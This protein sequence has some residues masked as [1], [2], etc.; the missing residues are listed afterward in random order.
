MARS[1]CAKPRRDAN[2]GG[3]GSALLANVSEPV[4]ASAMVARL[5]DLASPLALKRGFHRGPRRRCGLDVAEIAPP[6][7]DTLRW[8]WK[9]SVLDRNDDQGWQ[10]ALTAAKKHQ[11]RIGAVP[12]EP[13]LT[14]GRPRATGRS[15]DQNGASASDG[16]RARPADLAG[17]P[18]SLDQVENAATAIAGAPGPGEVRR[19][20]IPRAALAGGARPAVQAAVPWRP[21]T[22]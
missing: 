7:A 10:R 16:V 15:E 5:D 14:R 9:R 20:S 22:P 3:A 1:S 19:A 18:R 13:A 17:R 4:D 8:V 2:P 21:L 12:E 6:V 11:V